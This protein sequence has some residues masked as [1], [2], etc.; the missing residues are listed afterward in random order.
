M[1]RWKVE[2]NGFA[3]VEAESEDEAIEKYQSGDTVYEEN[4]VG[5]VTTVDEFFVEI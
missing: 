3:Y 5:E 4:E 2:F 1:E